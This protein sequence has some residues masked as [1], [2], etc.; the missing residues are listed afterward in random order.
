MGS[1]KKVVVAVDFSEHSRKAV[2]MAVEVASSFGASIDLIHVFEM[3]IPP[4]TP[5][6]LVLPDNFITEARESVL[7]ELETVKADIQGRGVSVESHL[8]DAPAYVA[9]NELAEQVGADLI[10][11]GTRGNTGIKHVVL[12]SVAE[13]TLRHAECPVLTVK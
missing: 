3:P 5:Y 2:D 8:G 12:G 13:R 6:E 10:V 11:M 7:R 1:I 4:V 9:I